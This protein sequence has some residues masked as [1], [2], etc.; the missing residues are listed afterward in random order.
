MFEQQLSPYLDCQRW[1]VGYS[2][3]LDSTVLLHA[4][5]T[6]LK[7]LSSERAVRN[8]TAPRLPE[9][10]AVHVDHQLM[11]E[12]LDWVAHCQH[13]CERQQIALEL[14]TVDVL[15]DGQGLENA[16]RNARYAVFSRYIDTP[17]HLLLSAHHQHDQAETV[18]LRLFR[19]AGMHGVGAMS[20]IR[21]FFSG[22]LAR[23]FLG[24]PRGVLQ[25]YANEHQLDYLEDPSNADDKFDRNFVRRTVLPL[26]AERWTAVES[27]LARFAGHAADNERL[28]R[29]LAH[30][31]V[32]S[33]LRGSKTY[34][35][36]LQIESL[37]ILASYRRANIYRFWLGTLGEKMPSTARLEEIDAL[38]LG[39][40]AGSKLIF[41]DYSLHVHSDGLYWVSNTWLSA[42][43]GFF[44]Q[45]LTWK[46]AEVLAVKSIGTLCV[47]TGGERDGLTPG[48]YQIGIRADGI[49]CR[50]NGQSK[51]LKKLLQ[52]AAIPAWLRDRYPI[53][54]CVQ[55]D[56]SRQVAAIGDQYICDDYRCPQGGAVNWHYDFDHQATKQL[57]W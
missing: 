22:R 21:P 49:E 15:V 32:S 46:T 42:L 6:L 19:G 33:G 18:L 52:K 5:Q 1:I 10:V 41:R 31:D 39:K 48:E 9:L 43:D 37:S 51:P 2:G 25:T 28:A 54:Y 40:R 44:M 13:F 12:H 20:T 24:I 7:R 45:P 29:D 56:G 55:S 8:A 11:P 17:H 36:C 27:S 26:I 35:E 53:I 50:L 57:N 23:P 47:A 3:G 38:V 34:G 16:A 4:C 30:L 14:Q